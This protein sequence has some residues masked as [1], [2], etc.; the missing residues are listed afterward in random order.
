[1][2]KKSVMD[3]LNGLYPHLTW[4]NIKNKINPDDLDGKN[5]AFMFFRAFVPYFYFEVERKKF[6]NRL[7]IAGKRYQCWCTG[8]PHLEN[9]GVLA[10][11]SG[12]K[13]RNETFFTMNDPDDGGFGDPATDLLRCMTGI[14]L[15]R[16]EIDIRK[17]EV[18]QTL[19][20]VMDAYR[21]GLKDDQWPN[22]LDEVL[23]FLK[24]RGVKKST[25][26][27]V[28]KHMKRGFEPDP[29]DFNDENGKLI[30]NG[31]CG[32]NYCMAKNERSR[33][34]SEIDKEFGSRYDLCD[35]I[36]F[37]KENGGSGGLIQ[38]RVLLRRR[39]P[40]SKTWPEW[41]VLDVKPQVRA[42]L[43]PL[44]KDRFKPR[45]S[46]SMDPKV[47]KKRTDTSLITERG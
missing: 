30:R 21:Q 33:V 24:D 36:K 15:A 37:S 46:T 10:Q 3:R 8:D 12:K 22:Q 18:D 19:Q 13:G 25:R 34:W 40:Q 32:S 14:R 38:Y 20:Q 45:I 6:L 39:K 2:N 23:D 17:K 9:F 44:F 26:K 7:A 28:Q 43:Y 1:M 42:G 5:S 11:F 47:I 29:D 35:L 16:S 27:D 41:V 4:E 31:S